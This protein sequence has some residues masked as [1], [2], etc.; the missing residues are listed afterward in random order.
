MKLYVGTSG[1]L[2]SWNK[3]GTLDWYVENSKLNAVEL[4]ASFYRFPY[5]NQVKHWSEV[6]KPLSW[7]IKVNRLVTH[8]YK[9]SKSSYPILEKFLNLFKPLEENI[10]YYLFQ[11]PPSLTP[12]ILES[13]EA[14]LDEF[15][16]K[17]KFALEPRSDE[18]LNAK[19]YSE[20][21]R[22]GVTFVSIDAPFARAVE[23]TSEDVYL[24]LHGRKSWYSY[25]YSEK[26]LKEILHLVEEKK[27]RRAYIF[28]NNDHDML[29][30]AQKLMKL[31]E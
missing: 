28:F 9:L 19:V 2:Y 25:N 31:K 20:L 3:G 1:W 10:A 17:E 4:N 16:I 6:G 15:D 13:V 23:K 11:L 26:E 27:P 12:K 14:L 18:W 5:P 8:Q 22:L 29:N 21:E 24:R 7:C 30:N